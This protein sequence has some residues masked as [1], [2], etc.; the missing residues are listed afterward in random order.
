MGYFPVRYD[1]RVV[2]YERKL[3]I[4]LATGHTERG[5]QI[6]IRGILSTFFKK[7]IMQFYG[8]FQSLCKL[9]YIPIMKFRFVVSPNSPYVG[10]TEPKLCIQSCQ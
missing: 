2:I 6:H 7:A 9:S 5:L 3:F 8:Y 10:C 4:R 1:A